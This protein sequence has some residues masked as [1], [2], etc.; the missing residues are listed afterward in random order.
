[1]A[2][3]DPCFLA[4][5]LT[6]NFRIGLIASLALKRGREIPAKKHNAVDPVIP[7]VV[8]SNADD[9]I[10]HGKI[11]LRSVA[12]A[13]DRVDRAVLVGILIVDVHER[14][15]LLGDDHDARLLTERNCVAEIAIEDMLGAALVAGDG[16]DGQA[17]ADGIGAG[18]EDGGDA[19]HQE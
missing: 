11:A 8:R 9:F 18:F 19:G 12:V 5:F 13:V 7:R 2:I 6:E 10:G 1:M 17:S 4:V 3:L 16:A 15:L 14:V